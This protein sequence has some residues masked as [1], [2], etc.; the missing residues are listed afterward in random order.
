M[1]PA[2]SEWLNELRY[3]WRRSRW[4]VR[5]DLWGL[6]HESVRLDRPVFMTG[7]QGGALTLLFRML[8]RLPS[9]VTVSGDRRYWGGADE[10]HVV[11]R[12]V[13]PESLRL[14]PEPAPY[15]KNVGWTYASDA[16]LPKYRRTAADLRP[17]EAAK[18][19]RLIRAMILLN[20]RD[21]RVARFL[22]KSQSY[23]VRVPLLRQILPG[24]RFSHKF[25]L[26][27]GH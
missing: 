3:T 20:S 12:S 10:M 14:K 27:A 25:S 22:D 8:V 13:L 11:L 1:V 21:H 6:P 9:S 18:V 16:L 4:M 19:R 2:G 5:P 17:A 23:A 15:G 7:V 24:A 26:S